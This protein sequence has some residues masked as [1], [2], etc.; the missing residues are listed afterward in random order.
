M[1]TKLAPNYANLFMANFENNFVFNYQIQ[2]TLYKG[3]IDDIFFIWND[4]PKELDRFISHLNSVHETIKFTKTTSTE[5]IIYLDLDIYIKS[6]I[7]HTKTHFK[8][9]NT[10]SYLH[11][12]SNH[13][14]STFKGV[15]KGVNIC[16][17]R[18][19]SEDETYKK[20]FESIQTHFKTRK[21]PTHLI[22]SPIIPFKDRDL[23]IHCTNQST[24]HPITLVTTFDPTVSIKNHLLLDWPRLSSDRE[25][26][27]SFQKPP[28]VSYRHSSN[29]SQLLVR[30]KLNHNI[31]T[32]IRTSPKPS[33]SVSSYPAKTSNAETNNV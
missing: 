30:A 4:T 31:T 11:G 2:P 1:G 15:Y 8:S 20:T 17:L 7:I 19:T 28:Q 23:Y 29:L 5:Q 16:I 13:P 3:F 6:K 22:N 10:F 27:H 18:N 33:I 12:H 25:L 32:H 26:R 24:A 21:Y 14:A 9:T